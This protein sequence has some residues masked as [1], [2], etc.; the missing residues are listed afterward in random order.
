MDVKR[1]RGRPPKLRVVSSQTAAQVL[2]P[3]PVPTGGLL[4]V[5]PREAAR[6]L[7]IGHSKLYEMIAAG[8]P[9][10]VKIGGVTLIPVSEL[11]ALLGE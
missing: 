5:R 8:R 4:A 2:R 1:K 9:R 6:M 10:T 3:D 11:R 7:S